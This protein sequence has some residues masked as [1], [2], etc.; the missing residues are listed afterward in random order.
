MV[1]LRCEQFVARGGAHGVFT[2]VSILRFAC[3]LQPVC[4]ALSSLSF[5]SIVAV[6][7]ACHVPRGRFVRRDFRAASGR[8][9]VRNFSFIY[10]YF[11]FGAAY[12]FMCSNWLRISHTSH[13]ARI[14]SKRITKTHTITMIHATRSECVSECE[15][16]T[17]ACAPP[18]SPA[19]AVVRSCVLSQRTAPSTT[20]LPVACRRS[21]R[22][23]FSLPPRQSEFVHSEPLDPRTAVP[24]APPWP[25]CP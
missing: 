7:R 4:I 24:P 14:H 25:C 13:G 6:P 20:P 19:A 8:K 2:P 5:P 18:P 11:F 9:G 22:P 16:A 23:A 12:C 21:F 1:K 3:N 17:S 15:C 10:F